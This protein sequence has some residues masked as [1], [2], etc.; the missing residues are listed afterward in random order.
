ME[1]VTILPPL[2]E[3]DS[4]NEWLYHYYEIVKENGSSEMGIL[5]MPFPIE[6]AFYRR[7]KIPQNMMNSQQYN[8]CKY[9]D[10]ILV[11]G[12]WR[13][14]HMCR[15]CFLEHRS[16]KPLFDIKNKLDS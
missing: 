5:K 6:K 8:N 4:N 1:N 16:G 12:Y 9:C 13:R 7:R 15:K 14:M 2:E 10:D 3:W 11:D